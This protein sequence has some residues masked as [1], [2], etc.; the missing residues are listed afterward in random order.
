MKQ[1]IK[2]KKFSKYNEGLSKRELRDIGKISSKYSINNKHFVKK[3]V[4]LGLV[5]VMAYTSHYIGKTQS[6][7][8]EERLSHLEESILENENNNYQ[9]G[10][11]IETGNLDS[12]PLYGSG[13]QEYFSQYNLSEK[14]KQ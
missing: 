7:R 4:K 6:I 14:T 9:S 10:E 2:N 5:L 3:A 13:L 1:K 11:R 12:E 8:Q